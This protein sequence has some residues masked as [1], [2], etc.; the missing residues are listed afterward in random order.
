MSPSN[1]KNR[2]IGK[3]TKSHE[4]MG[5][6][7]RQM[8]LRTQVQNRTYTIFKM[9][10]RYTLETLQEYIPKQYTLSL[11]RFWNAITRIAMAEMTK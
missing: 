5:A 4:I 2:I 3:R 6:P 8:R 7:A 10:M 1:T 9:K 11:P